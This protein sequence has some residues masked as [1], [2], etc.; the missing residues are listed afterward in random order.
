MEKNNNI[1]KAINKGG[2]IISTDKKLELKSV[3]ELELRIVSNSSFYHQNYKIKNFEQLNNLKEKS[4]NNL[5]KNHVEDHQ[6]LYNRVTLDLKTDNRL[7][8]IPTDKRIEA[9]KKGGV[10]IELQ[11][12]LRKGYI[13]GMDYF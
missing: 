5:K 7:Q 11:E 12:T 3:K 2:K 8:N 10:D 1:I 13:F 6:S 9:I 4:F